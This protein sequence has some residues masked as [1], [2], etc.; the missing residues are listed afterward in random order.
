MVRTKASVKRVRFAKDGKTPQCPKLEK[1]KGLKR[2]R[3]EA[4]PPSEV[5]NKKTP[6]KRRKQTK[7]LKE[8]K[9]QQKSTDLV[10]P[11]STFQRLVVEIGQDIS[12]NIRWAKKAHEALQVAAEDYLVEILQKANNIAVHAKRTTLKVDDLKFV[13]NEI[14]ILNTGLHEQ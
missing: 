2:T 13:S 12:S 1:P 4:C 9:E 5:V 7:W 14:D 8:I 11:K 10:F 6:K 3:F